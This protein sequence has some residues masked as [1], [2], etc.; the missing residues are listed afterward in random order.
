M[1]QD[2]QRVLILAFA[3]AGVPG[4]AVHIPRLKAQ[5]AAVR[6]GPVQHLAQLGAKGGLW[7][8]LAL[9]AVNAHPGPQGVHHGLALVFYDLVKGFSVHLYP[10]FT[11]C[12]KRCT[13]SSSCPWGQP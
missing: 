2:G 13:P 5:L 4:V 1:R 9:Q 10:S 11:A 7:G 12:A 8:G 6:E 3:Q